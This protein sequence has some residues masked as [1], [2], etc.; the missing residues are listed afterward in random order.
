MYFTSIFL[1][2]SSSTHIQWRK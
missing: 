1:Q 2:M